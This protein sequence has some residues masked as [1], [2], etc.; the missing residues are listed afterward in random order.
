MRLATLRD[1]TADGRLILVSPDGTHYADGPVPTLQAALENWAQAS[2]ALARIGVFPHNLDPAMLG[3]ALPRAWQWLDGSVYK[4]HADLLDKVL[5]V[6]NEKI[7]RPMMYQGVSDKFYGPCDD[8]FFPDET[9]MIDFEGEF[10]VIVDAVPMGT[11]A[12]EAM[13]HIKLLVQINDWSLRAGRAGNE[14]GL[15]LGS[16]QAA[17]FH[18]THCHYPGRTGRRLARWPHLPRSAG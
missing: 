6:A 17:L 7:D 16:G 15:W 11:T 13:A 10:G 14:I 18:G 5:G 3:A 9:L 4:A 1:G 12:E 2:P 8:V